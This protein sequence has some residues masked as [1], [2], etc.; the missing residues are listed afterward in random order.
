MINDHSLSGLDARVKDALRAAAS[1]IT[2]AERRRCGSARA[3][4]DALGADGDPRL[5]PVP[6]PR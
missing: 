4:G 5:T 3:Y 1:T 6:H 2:E